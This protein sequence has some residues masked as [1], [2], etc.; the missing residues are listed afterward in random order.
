MKIHSS[1]SLATIIGTLAFGG[2]ALADD[3]RLTLSGGEEM[4]R[5]ATSARG[6]G[7]ITIDSDMSV[8]GSVTAT[9]MTGT[10]AHIHVGR[11]GGNGPSAIVLT[12]IGD[13]TWIVPAGARLTEEQYKAYLAGELYINI[14]SRQHKGGEIRAQLIPPGMASM[15]KAAGN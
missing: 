4:P 11:T 10:V 13:N 7:V 6:D 3:V 8:S 12:K 1:T 5:V 9:G 15:P 2:I 14:H